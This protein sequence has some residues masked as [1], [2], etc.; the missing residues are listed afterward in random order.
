M[1]TWAH[2]LAGI[3][4]GVLVAPLLLMQLAQAW[5]GRQEVVFGW[6]LPLRAGLYA[7]LFFAIV[8]LGEDFGAPF[9]Y[10]QF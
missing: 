6:R 7:L 10:F 8:F 3:S 5:S 1:T 9:I 4:F 2:S